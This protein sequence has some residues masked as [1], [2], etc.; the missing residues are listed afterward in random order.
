VIHAPVLV[1]PGPAQLVAVEERLVRWFGSSSNGA[2][3]VQPV[4]GNRANQIR[5]AAA[6]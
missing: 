3:L 5:A 2:D 6:G 4:S 1:E